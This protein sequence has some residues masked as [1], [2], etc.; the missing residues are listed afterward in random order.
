[1]AKKVAEKK[2]VAKKGPAK[3]KAVRRAPVK[4]ASAVSASDM[5]GSPA[6]AAVATLGEAVKQDG[7]AVL[8]HF[9]E[10][11]GGHSVLL[12][13]LP[14]AFHNCVS[15]VESKLKFGCATALN[16]RL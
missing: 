4:V 12:V 5:A 3:K 15:K 14:I 6:P 2:K 7:C 11:F 1:M 8:A 13:A 16:C 9:R 10:P